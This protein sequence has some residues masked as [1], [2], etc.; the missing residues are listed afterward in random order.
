MPNNENIAE[1]LNVANVNDAALEKVQAERTKQKE[2]SKLLDGQPYDAMSLVQQANHFYANGA[3]SFIEAGKRL[4]AIK[5]SEKKGNFDKILEKDWIGSRRDAYTIM[6]IAIKFP[7]SA[8]ACTLG[9]SKLKALLPLPDEKIQELEA[10]GSFLGKTAED[11]GLMTTREVQDLV[12]KYTRRFEKE[13]KRADKAEKELE[14]LQKKIETDK[15][16]AIPQDDQEVRD[17]VLKEQIVI[18]GE[19]IAL[20]AKIAE[21]SNNPEKYTGRA[22]DDISGLVTYFYKQVQYLWQD[23][24]TM[25]GDIYDNVPDEREYIEENMP[26][27]GVL[28]EQEKEV[29]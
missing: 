16:K 10:G 18:D 17:W 26:T 25:L 28:G 23:T 9:K 1:A 22:S 24:H 5:E 8:H 29:Q 11:L 6:A 3:A 7:E 13:E 15:K 19:V 20:K 12:K 21:I 27:L 2:I 14:K 4:I